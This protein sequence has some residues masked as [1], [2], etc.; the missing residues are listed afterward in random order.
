MKILEIYDNGGK[1]V[2]RYTFVVEIEGNVSHYL[3]SN[4][5]GMPNGI[6]VY[7]GDKNEKIHIEGSKISPNDIPDVVQQFCL[8]VS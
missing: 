7:A 5:C 6:I 2:D 1:T 8:N 4:D 3:V